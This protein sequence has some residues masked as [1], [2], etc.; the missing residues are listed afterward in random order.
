LPAPER[1]HAAL[2]FP[3]VVVLL[4]VQPVLAVFSVP[5][6]V[7]VFPLAGTLVASLWSL[8]PRGHWFRVGLGLSLALLIA[9]VLHRFV[10]GRASIVAAFAGLI[11]L[12]AISVV[13]GV[14]WLF[15]S[16]RITVSTL[17]SAVSVYLLIGVTFGMTFVAIYLFE[18]SAFSGVSPAGQSAEI[19]E[20]MYYSLGAL[21]TSAFGDILPTHPITRLL[22]NVESVTGQLYMA[23]L[24]AILITG[25]AWPGP[26]RE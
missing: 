16:A 5:S 17:L 9:A 12:A 11:A 2:L 10:S 26:E 6:E 18:P 24:V 4:V 3:A 7:L 15:A 14:R 8:D 13:L 25:Y 20:L 1:L 23:V 21:S 22:A 19:A